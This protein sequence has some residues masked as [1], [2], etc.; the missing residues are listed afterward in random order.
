MQIL[1]NL[2]NDIFL[3]QNLS[4]FG[5]EL[6]VKDIKLYGFSELCKLTVIGCIGNQV[7]IENDRK[8]LR[9]L[10]KK[11]LEEKTALQPFHLKTS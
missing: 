10:T 4:F 7:N 6:F 1:N 8:I 9:V 11:E 5:L 2:I 3:G